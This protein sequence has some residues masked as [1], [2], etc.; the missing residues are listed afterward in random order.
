MAVCTIVARNYLGHARV[1]GA[2]VK[3]TNPEVRFVTLVIDAA[4]AEP[5]GGDVGDVFGLDDLGVEPE[6][7]EP[8][9]VMYSVMEL[10]TA[11]KPFLLT[12]LLA[13]G[14]DVVTYLDPDIEV[15]ADL[16]DVF[17]AARESAVAL[18]PHVLRP[19]PR[20]GME[21]SERTIMLAGMFNLG[22]VAVAPGAEVFLEWWQERLRTEAVVDFENGLFTDQRW[23]DWA[24]AFLDVA[25]LRD[26]GLNVAYWNAHERTLTRDGDGRLLVDD[27][28][29]RFFHFSGFD[30]DE[31]WLLS[32]FMGDHPRVLLSESEVLTRLCLDHASALDG[33]GHA[34]AITAPYGLAALPGGPVLTSE[35]RRVF[36][37]A[38]LSRSP[39]TSPPSR[40]FS[41][42]GA[43]REWLET[44]VPC[45][46]F[47]RLAPADLAIWE[48]SA[49]LQRQFPSVLGAAS[50]GFTRWL[51]DAPDLT[52]RYGALGLRP[53]RTARSTGRHK[54]LS[55]GWAIV[56]TGS[57]EP[58]ETVRH[59]AHLVGDAVGRA[60]V[61]WSVVEPPLAGGAEGQW[62]RRGTAP[63]DAWLENLVVCIDTEHFS[64]DRVVE[65]LAERHGA[66]VALWFAPG[67]E[68][69]FGCGQ[70][71]RMFD[72]HWVL[73]EAAAN[74]VRALGVAA[75]E[76]VTLPN[77]LGAASAVPGWMA[78]QVAAGPTFLV[79]VDAS[80]SLSRRSP[81]LAVRAFVEAFEP[82]T[83]RLVVVV[84]GGRMTRQQAETL[85]QT[86]RASSDVTIVE[87]SLDDPGLPAAVQ[88]SAGV[89][90]LHPSPAFDVVAALAEIAGVPV[91]RSS[92]SAGPVG[93]V[94]DVMLVPEVRDENGRGV[95]DVDA[96]AE[97]LA[98]LATSV[99][100]PRARAQRPSAI[101]R[102]VRRLTLDLPGAARRLV[103][104][105]GVRR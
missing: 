37:N 10:A 72:E 79:P 1:L 25:I 6:V 62:P 35:I 45:L 58:A 90:V 47:G 75:I 34:G 11:L 57:P 85:R 76:V 38:L 4:S 21:I 105:W 43:L 31:P 66:R 16:D 81:E 50:V 26:P 33:A 67:D 39:F 87:V 69:P 41:E 55:S 24:P 22:F 102:H 70:V 18:T 30:P 49:E 78:E 42:P 74:V 89:V 13:Q 56:P 77:S 5:L 59:V 95:P 86:A 60:G 27:G 7:L 101:T 12:A 52:E 20:D 84:A 68:L 64:E 103:G 14:H 53:S 82:G 17:A 54:R 46:A 93:T 83:A 19:L 94:P 99:P 36:R 61:P 15:Y 91:V 40:P 8:M 32:R 71:A 3:R 100:R 63:Q 96:A 29:L 2:S 9:L 48:G 23:V 98:R 104:R 51:D 28:P 73:T 65:A 44:P 97:V 92:P 80:G 88:A